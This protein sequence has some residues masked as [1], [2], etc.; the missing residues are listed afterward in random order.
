MKSLLLHAGIIL[1]AMVVLSCTSEQGQKAEG[2]EPPDAEKSAF[3]LTQHGDTR[4]DNYYW[5]KLTDDQ[6]TAESPDEQTQ[7]V[8]SY[9]E[10]ENDYLGKIMGH[11]EALQETL[12]EEIIGRI[13]QTDESVPY[14]SNGYWYYY[15]YE[16]GKEYRIYC[17][18]EGSMEAEEEIVLNVNEWGEGKDFINI[19][20]LSVSPNNKI[21]SFG[22]DTISRRQYVLHF[23]DLET[24]EIYSDRVPNSTGSVAWANDNK[25]LFYTGKEEGTLRSYKIFRHKL[26]EDAS[27]DVEIFHEDDDTYSTYVFRSKSGS[28]VMIGS[29]H[30]LASEYR[31][32]DADNPDGE[33]KLFN[34]RER[35]HEYYVNHF[36][37]KFY[38]LTNWDA[39]NYK[40]METGLENTTQDNWKE[41][42]AHRDDVL[43][44]DIEIFNGYLVLEERKNG[45]MN[46]RIIN[47]KTGDEHYLDFGEEAYVAYTSVNR[48]FDTE[49]LRY[50]YQSMTTPNSTYDYDMSSKEKTLLKQQEVVGEFNSEDYETKRLYAEATDGT[51]I[52]ISMVYKKGMEKN[53][54]NPTLLYGYGSY[55]ATIDPFFSS[56]RLSLLDRGFV[57]AIAHI[58]GGQIM[59][60]QWY[61]DGKMGKKKNTFTDFI[62]C[63]QYLIDEEY[64]NPNMLFAQGG[65]AGGL[66]MGAVA[67]MSPE[68]FKGMVARV[69]FVDVVTTMLDESIPLTTGEF[70]EW[71]NPKKLEEYEYILSYSPYDN[72]ADMEYPNMLITTG[73]HDSQVQY[74]EP[75]KWVAKLRDHQKANNVILLRTEMEVG[76]GGAS[77]RFK[78]HKETALIYAFL[79]DLAGKSGEE[80]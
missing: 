72:V 55:G 60:R 39:K 34:P 20:G 61:E 6:K 68:L 71:G 51:M 54:A 79:L 50:G 73:F 57:F 13:K 1:T 58:R 24:G 45:L 59:G 53:G 37:D 40:L 32:L 69:P 70:D 28:Y 62:D 75:A 48:E 36:R 56:S 5:M 9:L 76:H 23:K 4:I 46:L 80:S 15:R 8:V 43:L 38:V 47:Q 78:R 52:P 74:W 17:R 66:L 12:Y 26:G 63:A 35:N 22:V 64:T 42:I 41:V 19:R 14:F 49:I 7:Q 3:E 30:T 67:N 77:G 25:T 21:L 31:I 16:E 27:G 33:F 11:T 44:D 10:A 65:S 2:P 18:R 29:F